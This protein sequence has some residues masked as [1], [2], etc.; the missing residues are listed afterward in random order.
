MHKI[1]SSIKNM[2][3]YAGKW[4]AVDWE[5]EIIIAVGETLAEIAPLVSGKPDQKEPIKAS[6]FKVPQK[7]D[8]PVV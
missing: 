3:H 1:K 2:A 5:K 8:F 4:V 7:D 6:A